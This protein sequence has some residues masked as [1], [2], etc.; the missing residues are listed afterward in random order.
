MKKL[1]FLL[2]IPFC[3][4]GQTYIINKVGS[5][6]VAYAGEGSGF[7][8]YTDTDPTNVIK[9]A[10]AALT[11]AGAQG[12]GGGDIKISSGL[13]TLTD[14]IVINGW[15]SA[16]PYSSVKI[17]GPALS[18]I[19]R[20]STANKHAIVIKNRAHVDLY[21][22][23]IEAN[24]SA[25]AAIYGDYSGTDAT[26]VYGGRWDNLFLYSQSTSY[27]ALHLYNPTYL[28]AGTIT[29]INQN[30]H[31]VYIE[32]RSTTNNF[33]NSSFEMLTVMASNTSPYAGLAIV[34][35][36]GTRRMNL[37]TVNNY[38]QGGGGYYGIAT[39]YAGN[40]H[41]NYVAIEAV[42]TCIGLGVLGAG[43]SNE[44]NTMKFSAGYLRPNTGGTGIKCSQYTGANTFED[45]W[46]E[47]NA[48]ATPIDDASSSRNPNKYVL[49]LGFSAVW[50]NNV[51]S[52]PYDTYTEYTTSNTPY[53]RATK[54]ASYT[55]LVTMTTTQRDAMTSP[56]NGTKL[57]N[58]TTNKEQ[59]RAS[60]AWVDD[61]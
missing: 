36:T 49:H 48:T 42:N 38:Q 57:Y 5:T 58:S 23:R 37:C 16:T 60:G 4:F 10:I 12:T 61:H 45:L 22:M 46:F 2:L 56:V 25:R 17:T 40:W 14:E 6:Y 13:Y 24:G 52:R 55:E 41:F 54:Q 47:G 30:N 43:S 18:T 33:G 26:S 29:A 21:D 19:L 59:V 28:A 3:S 11:P 8:D 27:A 9:N 35:T 50:A 1:L 7:S 44:T 53:K 32:Q 15:E 31:A 20:Q 39:S 51:I 34:N